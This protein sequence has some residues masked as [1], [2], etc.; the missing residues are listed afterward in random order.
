LY[1]ADINGTLFDKEN[2]LIFDDILNG[3]IKNKIPGVNS[4][5]LYVGC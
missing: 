2:G 1:G 4:P 3:G 5:Y